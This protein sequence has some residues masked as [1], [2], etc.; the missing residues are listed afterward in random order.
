MLNLEK[1][2]AVEHLPNFSQKCL[3]LWAEEFHHGKWNNF[4]DKYLAITTTHYVFSCISKT[5]N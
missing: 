5:S 4:L 1:R 2:P 3:S